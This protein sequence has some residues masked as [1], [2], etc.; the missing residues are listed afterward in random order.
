[1]SARVS[2]MCPRTVSS[3]RVTSTVKHK[4]RLIPLPGVGT[5]IAGL[6]CNRGTEVKMMERTADLMAG[7]AGSGRFADPAIGIL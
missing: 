4:W 6:A 5:R 7:G 3:L 1:M 2:A